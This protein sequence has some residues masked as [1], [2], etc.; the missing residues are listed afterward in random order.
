MSIQ[1][2]KEHLCASLAEVAENSRPHLF[3]NERR[4]YIRTAEGRY[5]DAREE[6]IGFGFREA[7]HSRPQPELVSG[8]A[9][10]PGGEPGQAVRSPH[11]MMPDHIGI[12]G[13]AEGAALCHRTICVVIAL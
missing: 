3:K 12:V 2:T 4:P 8:A 9:S 1:E 10:R 11:R 5:G 13:S 6:G 7:T